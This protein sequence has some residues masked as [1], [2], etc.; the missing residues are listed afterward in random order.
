MNDPGLSAYFDNAKARA[1]E[2]INKS[3]A[4]TGAYGASSAN[5]QT[6]RAFSD[7]EAQ[8][9]FKEADYA[10]QR[11]A[12]DRAWQG[13]G[14]ELA[15]GA[16]SHSGAVSEDERR[17]ADLLSGM[18][19]QVDDAELRRL[20]AAMDASG[21]AQ[22]AERTRG[23]DYF[24]NTAAAGDRF[25][26]QQLR[27]MLQALGVDPELFLAESSGNVAQGNAALQNET[28]NA[29]TTSDAA[30]AALAFTQ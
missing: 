16:D 25:S 19:G 17:W 28:S 29:Q 9:A 11:A 13:L 4:A 24:N 21:L 2:S 18:G 10:L 12:E 15:G 8:R 30:Q 22:G 6:A 14:G 23:Q 20:N 7:L 26:D 27:I 1:A 3:A 5:D